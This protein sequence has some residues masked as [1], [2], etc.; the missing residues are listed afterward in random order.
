MKRIKYRIL[1]KK[2]VAIVLVSAMTASVIMSYDKAGLLFKSIRTVFAD[3]VEDAEASSAESEAT[4]VETTAAPVE[5]SVENVTPEDKNETDVIDVIEGENETGFTD[6]ENTEPAEPGTTE[7][8]ETDI[9]ETES[10]EEVP[11]EPENNETKPAKPD[12]EL[13]ERKIK[14]EGEDIYVSGLLPADVKVTAEK[15]E[16]EVSGAKVIAAY[17]I[18]VFD[19]NGNEWQP[20]EPLKIE[21]ASKECNSVTK[22]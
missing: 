8:T 12:I 5:T 2:L 19:K 10:S 3:E 17:D 13:K 15:V 4:V 11:S 16:V 6:I 14:A 21:V 1:S 7:S 9:K 22:K 18:K 20:A